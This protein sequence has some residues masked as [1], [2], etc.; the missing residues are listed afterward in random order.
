MQKLV[1]VLGCVF[2]ALE[3]L[4]GPFKTERLPRPA[5]ACK[6][7]LGHNSLMPSPSLAKQPGFGHPRGLC[8]PLTQCLPTPAQALCSLNPCVHD[9][10]V[11][12]EEYPQ[13]E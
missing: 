1:L 5:A 2:T 10:V 13:W 6:M 3:G 11:S 7:A 8:C 4:T 9:P 12:M